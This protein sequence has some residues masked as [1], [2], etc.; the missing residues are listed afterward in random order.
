MHPGP[1][2]C[3]LLATPARRRR[4]CAL[5]AAAASTDI[6]LEDDTLSAVGCGGRRTPALQ[7][8]CPG[9]AINEVRPGRGAGKGSTFGTVINRWLAG[10][11]R[12]GVLATGKYL[13]I[14]VP[15]Q[16]CQVQAAMHPPP[17]PGK[18]IGNQQDSRS[19]VSIW[20]SWSIGAVSGWFGRTLKEVSTVS[21]MPLA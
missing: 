10:T 19:T 11:P 5:A 6:F 20:K 14:L 3:P 8:R 9:H 18:L 21:G 2:V 16:Y 17:C 13:W 12:M 7:H 15:H 1:S 4:V